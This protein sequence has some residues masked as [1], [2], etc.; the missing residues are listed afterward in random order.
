MTKLAADSAFLSVAERLAARLRSLANP[1]LAAGAAEVRISQAEL[2][3]FLGV[4]RQVVNG[5]LQAWKRNG[6]VDL[7]R[8]TIRIKDLNAL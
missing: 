1:Q 5:Y 6:L 3:D 8:G 2:A 4:S 7:G